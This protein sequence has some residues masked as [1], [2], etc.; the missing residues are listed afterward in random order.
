MPENQTAICEREIAMSLLPKTE[1]IE[2]PFFE[3]RQSRSDRENAQTKALPV[4]ADGT[5]I[6]L[7]HLSD[8]L[9]ARIELLRIIGQ[10]DQRRRDIESQEEGSATYFSRLLILPLYLFLGRLMGDQCS[11]N[12]RS[13]CISA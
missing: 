13:V 5:N 1:S 9:A 4:S 6:L 3:N 11:K 10:A 7:Q 2:E 12:S 8:F